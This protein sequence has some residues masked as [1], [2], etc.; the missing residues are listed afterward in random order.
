[1]RSCRRGVAQVDRHRLVG[2]VD[3]QV[4]RGGWMTLG[5]RVVACMDEPQQRI[6]DSSRR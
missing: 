6:G 2:R 1:M 5:H 3:Q 4:V